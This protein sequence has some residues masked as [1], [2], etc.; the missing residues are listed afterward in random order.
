M[1]DPRRSLRPNSPQ[2]PTCLHG[3][4]PEAAGV[5]CD[6]NGLRRCGERHTSPLCRA[7][8]CGGPGGWTMTNQKHELMTVMLKV[9]VSL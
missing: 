8:T 1:P 7:V 4:K 3:P 2:V 9:P 6:A 5:G